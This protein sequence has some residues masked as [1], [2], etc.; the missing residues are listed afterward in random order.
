MFIRANSVSPTVFY[1]APILRDVNSYFGERKRKGRENGEK[2][3]GN[4]FIC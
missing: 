3:C 4:V 1:G 2:F